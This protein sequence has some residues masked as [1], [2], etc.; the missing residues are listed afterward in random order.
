MVQGGALYTLADF[1]FA[2]AANAGSITATGQ[3]NTVTLSA[4]ITYLRP[5]RIGEKLIAT[6]RR[7]RSGRTTCY[8]E[9]NVAAESDT[10][11][12]IAAVTVSGVSPHRS[13]K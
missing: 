3:P 13:T 8:Y 12:I 10:E 4:N 1:C 2:V 11:K 6:A 9:V 5:A 7:V